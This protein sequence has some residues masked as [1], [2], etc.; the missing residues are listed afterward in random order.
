VCRSSKE[1]GIGMLGQKCHRNWLRMVVMGELRRAFEQRKSFGKGRNC[2]L[3]TMGWMPME[4]GEA[5]SVTRAYALGYILPAKMEDIFRAQVTLGRERFW[6]LVD[7]IEK[8]PDAS[9]ERPRGRDG[10]LRMCASAGTS[11]QRFACL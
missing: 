7:S 6:S 3:R 4:E 10:D 8:S 9:K 11:S 2:L 5:I 1:G